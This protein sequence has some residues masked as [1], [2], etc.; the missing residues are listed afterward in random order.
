MILGGVGQEVRDDEQ[1][2]VWPLCLSPCHQV[3]EFG[4]GNST[5]EVLAVHEPLLKTDAAVHVSPHQLAGDV[6]STVGG[7]CALPGAL[8]PVDVDELHRVEQIDGELLELR[9]IEPLEVKVTP[10][11]RLALGSSRPRPGHRRWWCRT[12]GGTQVGFSL[13]ANLMSSTI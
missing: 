6:P 10:G 7:T 12:V 1:R 9:V 4:R 13:A 2:R 3:V 11:R 8:P 5:R